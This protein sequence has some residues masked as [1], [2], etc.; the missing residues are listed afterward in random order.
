MQPDP[1]PHAQNLPHEAMLT[2]LKHVIE[3]GMQ[4]HEIGCADAFGRLRTGERMRT[5]QGKVAV[6]T[7]KHKPLPPRNFVVKDKRILPLGE[8]EQLAIAIHGEVR[9]QRLTVQRR[10]VTGN[11][12][13]RF[14]MEVM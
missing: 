10:V 8:D 13:S 5:I 1:V 12:V 9:V 7:P 2:A 4:V 6:M 3:L 11:H 14:L